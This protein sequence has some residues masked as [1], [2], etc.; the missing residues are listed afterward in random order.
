MNELVFWHKCDSEKYKA[1]W[2]KS[3]LIK[4]KIGFFFFQI[5]IS[6]YLYY[7]LRIK[8]SVIPNINQNFSGLV[9]LTL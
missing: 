3:P 8:S 4:I 6:L 1:W 5:F 9:V 2:N 7:A